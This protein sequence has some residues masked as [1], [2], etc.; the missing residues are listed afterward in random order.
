MGSKDLF[1]RCRDSAAASGNLFV[2]S[3]YFFINPRDQPI[4]LDPTNRININNRL[5]L[6]INKTL[7]FGGGNF[8]QFTHLLT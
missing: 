7:R 3:S 2:S 6:L 5:I 8:Y 1:M 4:I